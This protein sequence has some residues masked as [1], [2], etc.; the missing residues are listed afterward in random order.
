MTSASRCSP[1]RTSSR[2][3][4]SRMSSVGSHRK[5]SRR[6]WRLPRKGSF[7][8]RSSFFGDSAEEQMEERVDDL[9][10]APPAAGLP[11]HG[12]PQHIAQQAIGELG[13]EVG[14]KHAA[15]LAALE[16]DDPDFFDFL[17]GFSQVP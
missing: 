1:P 6:R 5:S 2:S 13:V 14:A 16:L 7:R 4:T 10:G 12:N 9:F 17:K 3:A 8:W 15:L 11:V